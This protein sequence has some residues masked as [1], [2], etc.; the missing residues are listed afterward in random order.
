VDTIYTQ[1]PL[2]K[3]KT[4]NPFKKIGTMKKIIN[5]KLIKENTMIIPGK[6]KEINGLSKNS[7]KTIIFSLILASAIQLTI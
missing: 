1:A 3:S 4:T 5:S 6:R 7:M 2:V